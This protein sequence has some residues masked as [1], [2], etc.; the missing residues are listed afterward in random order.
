MLSK[1]EF[2]ELMSSNYANTRARIQWLIERDPRCLSCEHKFIQPE[3]KRSSIKSGLS[4]FLAQGNV[5][6]HWTVFLS[7]SVV[8]C[9]IVGGVAVQFLSL[10]CSPLFFGIGCLIPYMWVSNKINKRALLFA[11]DFPSVLLAT[12][13]SIR[14]GMTPLSALERAV[15]LLP[16]SSLCKQ[17]TLKLMKSLEE[18]ESKESALTH[19]AETIKL[20]EVEL[21]R[22]AFLLVLENGGRFSPTLHRLARVTR[23]RTTLVSAAQVSTASMRMT[24]TVLLCVV[25]IILGILSGS[26][27]D[28]FQIMLTNQ[29]ANNIATG[30]IV[31]I[32]LG[33]IILRRMSAFKP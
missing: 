1:L 17:E 28:Y 20:P 12:S 5:K 9:I 30:G 25:P 26:H 7:I 23:D 14:A 3:T 18:A 31:V 27:K 24:G 11:E 10:Y 29:M 4:L 15:E 6:I 32:T 22:K 16:Q 33:Q 19:Y 21:F 13:A 8:F 2:S